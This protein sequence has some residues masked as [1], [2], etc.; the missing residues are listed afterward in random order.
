MELICKKEALDEKG[1]KVMNF[2]KGVI[3]DFEEIGDPEGWE[4]MD[5]N[6]DKEVFFNLDLLFQSL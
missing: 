1:N 6:G 2:T 5:D 3:Y 4:T